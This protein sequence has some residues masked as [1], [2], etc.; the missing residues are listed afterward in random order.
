[1]PYTSTS[2]VTPAVLDHS[3]TAES[4]AARGALAFH[5]RVPEKRPPW[6][7]KSASELVVA[8]V[9]AIV[10]VMHAAQQVLMFVIF[11]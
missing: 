7:K 5:A 3:S 1:M 6:T 2:A 8:V 9:V 10:I 4:P 11:R